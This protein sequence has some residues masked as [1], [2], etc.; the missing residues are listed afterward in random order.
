MTLKE[1]SVP[2]TQVWSF[3]GCWPKEVG[4]FTLDNQ[5]GDPLLTAVRFGCL[6][7]R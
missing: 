3:T 2:T 6:S 4:G 1:R 7:M 5:S